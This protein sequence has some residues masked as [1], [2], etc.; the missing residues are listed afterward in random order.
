MKFNKFVVSDKF[1]AKKRKIIF[2]NINS[3]YVTRKINIIM[4]RTESIEETKAKI[5]DTY[6]GVF[7]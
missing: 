1:T 6:N 5:F 4:T 2:S 7:K 3:K